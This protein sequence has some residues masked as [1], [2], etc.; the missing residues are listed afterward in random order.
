MSLYNND[1]T[2]AEFP[3]GVS[4]GGHPT[5]EGNTDYRRN[6]WDHRADPN[7]PNQRALYGMQQAS[8]YGQGG[9]KKGAAQAPEIIYLKQGQSASSYSVQ[10]QAPTVDYAALQQQQLQKQQQQLQAQQQAQQRRYE[11]DLKGQATD[12]V[13][14][15]LGSSLSASNLYGTRYRAPGGAEYSQLVDKEFGRLMS[16][17]SGE[18]VANQTDAAAQKKYTGFKRGRGFISEPL[19]DRDLLG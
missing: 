8:G 11:A 17:D 12:I 6:E 7:D 10:Q 15:R 3:G 18:E 19:S 4:G 14:S 2:I 16:M 13:D 1:G 5:N 9:G